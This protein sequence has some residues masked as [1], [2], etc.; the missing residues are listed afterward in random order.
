MK[1]KKHLRSTWK[2]YFNFSS[3]EKK[4]VLYLAV[5]ITIQLSLLFAL[6]FY[7]PEIKAPDKEEFFRLAEQLKDSDEKKIEYTRQEVQEIFIPVLFNP[8]TADDS[9]LI[10]NG[11]TRK[12]TRIIRN[13]VSKGGRFRVKADVAKIYSIDTQTFERILP[14]IDLPEKVEV[15]KKAEG[16]TVVELS[17]ADSIALVELKGIGPSLASRIIKYRNALG[18]FTSIEQLKEVYGISDSLFLFIQPF[19][20]L[21]TTWPIRQINL[22]T[23]S[24]S[25]LI[26]HPY[27]RY[28]LGYGI[29]NYR[30]QHN[31]FKNVD[32][33]INL[34]FVTDEMF[35]KLVPY[36]KRDL[37]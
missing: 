29:V 6:R 8:N 4:G 20:K 28:K 22:N 26:V 17:T 33:L 36:L 5:I 37:L 25:T 2:N 18:G 27:I 30:K 10:R 11:L 16:K 21:N 14:Y 1:P 15:I 24:V 3:R 7:E 9:I 12:Q 34:P 19:I 31:G 13:F 35:R 23:D 32:E